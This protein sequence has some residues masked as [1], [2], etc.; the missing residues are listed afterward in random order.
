MRREPSRER[1][2]ILPVP[3]SSA[4]FASCAEALQAALEGGRAAEDSDSDSAR[5]L[6]PVLASEIPALELHAVWLLTGDRDEAEAAA[7]A[8]AAAA[9][10]SAAQ[11]ARAAA[12]A[13]AAAEGGSDPFFNAEVHCSVRWAICERPPPLEPTP[14]GIDAPAVQGAAPSQP[15]CPAVCQAPLTHSVRGLCA[16]GTNPTLG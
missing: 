12:A 8:A 7:E 11:R 4:A 2:R 6:L 1:I 10:A 16:T 13:A 9:E 15:R 5:G 3:S 14:S